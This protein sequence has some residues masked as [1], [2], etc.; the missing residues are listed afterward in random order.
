MSSKEI[1][2]ILDVSREHLIKVLQRLAQGG[3]VQNQRGVGGGVRLQKQAHEIRL[4]SLVRWLEEGQGLVEC[5]R[6]EGGHC[7]LT[8]LCLLKPL[9]SDATEAFYARLNQ[10]T[11]ADCLHPPLQHFV[12]MRA[13][14]TAPGAAQGRA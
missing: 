7:A 14:A 2:S 6:P 4:G 10:A 9:L 5:L 12:A 11:L 13:Q 3:Y 1:A 8:P